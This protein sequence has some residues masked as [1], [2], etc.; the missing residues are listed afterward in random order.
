[1]PG[2][3][4]RPTGGGLG[5]LGALDEDDVAR[6]SVSFQVDSAISDKIDEISYDA[7]ATLPTDRAIALRKD[8]RSELRGR[9]Y[10]DPVYLRFVQWVME[11][12]GGFVSPVVRGFVRF[13]YQQL[14]ERVNEVSRRGEFDPQFWQERLQA[15]VGKEEAEVSRTHPYWDITVLG[16]VHQGELPIRHFSPDDGRRSYEM[17]ADLDPARVTL[18]EVEGRLERTE[19]WLRVTFAFEGNVECLRFAN[20]A[21]GEEH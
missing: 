4:A 18:G 7:A 16:R 11:A 1:M 8:L 19:V 14:A 10:R 15:V 3:Q 17:D 9:L 21:P 5:M 12:A 13:Y 20:E 6:V 2:L